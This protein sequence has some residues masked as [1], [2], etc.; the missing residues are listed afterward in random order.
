MPPIISA[1][2]ELSSNTESNTLQ[3]RL[4]RSNHSAAVPMWLN[5]QERKLIR[6]EATK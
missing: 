2:P 1:E 5:A 6:W 4:P 3:F